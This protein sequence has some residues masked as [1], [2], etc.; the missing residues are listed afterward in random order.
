[1]SPT[2]EILEEKTKEV[3]A[4][5]VAEEAKEEEKVVVKPKNNK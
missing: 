5:P 4:E 2:G 3:R 1:V